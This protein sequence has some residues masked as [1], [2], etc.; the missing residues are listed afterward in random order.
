MSYFLLDAFARFFIALLLIPLIIYMYT[1]VSLSFR[2]KLVVGQLMHLLY[3]LFL[4]FLTDDLF[5]KYMYLRQE[6]K[7]FLA[8]EHQEFVERRNLFVIL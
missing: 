2:N 7:E 6:F 4:V 8:Q 3:V 1:K 5:F